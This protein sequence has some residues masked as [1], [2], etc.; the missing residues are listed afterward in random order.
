MVFFGRLQK[1]NE[2]HY[3]RSLGILIIVGKVSCRIGSIWIV[4]RVANLDKEE[5]MDRI[6]V[7]RVL[8]VDLVMNL[9]IV[10]HLDQFI[11]LKIVFVLEIIVEN[12]MLQFVS[13]FWKRVTWRQ[14]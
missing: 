8:D 4:S 3:S 13:T 9:A 7:C 6:R 11:M 12:I 10:L 2:S 5:G 14:R 1:E